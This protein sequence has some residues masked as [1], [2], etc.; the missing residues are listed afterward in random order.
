LGQPICHAVGLT[1][2]GL[3]PDRPQPECF[4]RQLESV[5]ERLVGDA[6]EIDEF[7]IRQQARLDEIAAGNAEIDKQFLECGVVPEGN[8]NGLV[9]RDPVIQRSSRR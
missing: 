7:R 8:G 6:E 4:D 2:C 1:G 3:H 5:L 9:L